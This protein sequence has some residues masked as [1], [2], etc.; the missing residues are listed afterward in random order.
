MV[1]CKVGICK[2]C[3]LSWLE[4]K[5]ECPHCR[6]NTLSFE[7]WLQSYK[8]YDKMLNEETNEFEPLV[9]AMFQHMCEA[10]R[11]LFLGDFQVHS[12]V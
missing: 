11:R 4:Y 9:V 12:I 7:L 3:L 5:R 8:N 2:K 10:Y 6:Q 1:C